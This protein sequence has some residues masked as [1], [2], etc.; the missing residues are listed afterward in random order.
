MAGSSDLRSYDLSREVMAR[1]TFDEG[2]DRGGIWSADGGRIVFLSHRGNAQN[3][4]SRL[5]DGSGVPERLTEGPDVD[6]P[7][8]VSPDGR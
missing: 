1:L 2:V 6:N 4:Y 8:S 3:L 5:A 7:Y